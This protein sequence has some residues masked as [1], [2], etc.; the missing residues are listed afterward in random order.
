M[1]TLKA[2]FFISCLISTMLISSC[3]KAKIDVNFN[4][5]GGNIY[6]TVDTI[7]QTGNVELAATTFSTDLAQ[8]LK[9]NSATM[10]DIESITLSSA[11]FT[12]Q[13][14]GAQNF[15]IVEKAYAF[16]SASGLSETQ[17]ASI[18][19]VPNGVTEISLSTGSA[20]LKDY[21]KQSVVNIRLSGFTSGPNE[22]ADSLKVNLKFV[23]KAK[24]KA[25]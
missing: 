10:D 1:K 5:Y 2:L 25:S 17:V 19:P 9:E 3:E 12:M 16:M 13:N 18:D 22:Q 14:P 11:M 23:V 21:I 4:V 7:T 24:V 6:M 20:N 15:D 8:K